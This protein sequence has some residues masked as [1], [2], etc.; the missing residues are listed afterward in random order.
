MKAAFVA[1]TAS[2]AAAVASACGGAGT[3]RQPPPIDPRVADALLAPDVA[4]MPPLPELEGGHGLPF[5]VTAEQYDAILAVSEL[6]ISGPWAASVGPARVAAD[7]DGATGFFRV[8]AEI[9]PVPNLRTLD[10]LAPPA[11]RIEIERVVDSTGTDVFDETSD[12]NGT[13]GAPDG[14]LEPWDIEWFLPPGFHSMDSIYPADLSNSPEH[15]YVARHVGLVDGA[16]VA[17]VEGTLILRLPTECTSRALPLDGSVVEAYGLRV[18][19]LREE[20]GF[21]LFA[22]GDTARYGGHRA[23]FE[24]DRSPD[25]VSCSVLA[26][27][28]SV[29]TQPPPTETE[30]RCGFDVPLVSIDVGFCAGFHERRFPFVLTAPGADGDA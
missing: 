23:T 9:A 26:P 27:G 10:P 7:P 12:E 4:E 29:G 5:R 20:G 11:V 1:L 24:S 18:R 6:N 13:P 25:S 14:W 17:R 21:R 3:E 2:L 15:R 8:D 28:G 22:K 16:I 30:L 19:A